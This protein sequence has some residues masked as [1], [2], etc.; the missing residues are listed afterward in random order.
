M[1]HDVSTANKHFDLVAR[2]ASPMKGSHIISSYFDWASSGTKKKQEWF[3]EQVEQLKKKSKSCISERKLNMSNVRDLP[4][5][6]DSS[7]DNI[8]DKQIFD[9]IR[10]FWRYPWTKPAHEPPNVEES[11]NC[12]IQRFESNESMPIIESTESEYESD[13]SGISG[14]SETS[15]HISKSTERNSLFTEKDKKIIKILCAKLIVGGKINKYSVRYCLGQNM[16]GKKILKEFILCRF[17]RGYI[18]SGT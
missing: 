4:M 5:M 6:L 10:D 15:A 7:F 12:K 9:K 3:D 8:S 17:T 13:T 16:D 18:M 11:L 1:A 14:S 2:Q